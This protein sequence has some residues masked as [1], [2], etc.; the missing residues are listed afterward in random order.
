M[1]KEKAVTAFPRPKGPA[2]TG[3]GVLAPTGLS[4]AEHWDSVLAG[5]SGI[6]RITRFDP[7]GYP[8]QLAGELPGFEKGT[9]PGRL[10]PQTD[11]WTHI[12]LTAAQQALADAGVDPARRPEYE[13]AVVTSSSS[14]GT[15]FG[16][17]EM[18][19][20]YTGGPSHVGAYQS[21]AWFYAATTGQ[22]SILHGMRGPCGVVA[23][24]QAGGLESLRQAG[25]LLSQGIGLVVAGGTDGSLCPYGLTAQIANGM[26]S[27]AT[28]PTKAYAPFDA[29]ASGYLPGEGGAI[30]VL[31]DYDSALARGAPVYGTVAGYGAGF[32]P[33]PGSPR[34]PALRRVIELALADAGIQAADI[35]V[36]FADAMGVP[37][38]DRAEARALTE[39]FGPHG[40]P[41]TAPK[42]LTGR[43]YGGGSSLDVATALLAL[44]DD[45][46]PATA[47]TSQLA[48]GCEDLD[49]VLGEPRCR[50]LHTALVVARG[51]GGFTAAVVLRSSGPGSAPVTAESEQKGKN[52]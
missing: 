46:V 50:P 12:G 35:D 6:G 38:A 23:C 51:Y 1:A 43:L 20:L 37:A 29:E 49:I 31:E 40:T 2:V 36:V 32:D 15:E 41:V 28:D 9:V 34:P 22:I 8:V 26:V 18:T 14:G 21:I 7:S 5:K 39:V 25:R 3:I 10:V 42:T 30:F 45:T 33:P 19:K 16:Q 47:A 11:R 27:E 13:M 17:H 44:R 24:E 4:T 48:P 52:E